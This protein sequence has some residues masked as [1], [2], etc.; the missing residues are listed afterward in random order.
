MGN[1]QKSL[2]GAGLSAALVP[3]VLSISAT[4]TRAQP[5][6]R[7][8]VKEPAATRC[9]EGT[10]VGQGRE[11]RAGLSPEELELLRLRVETERDQLRLAEWRLEQAQSWESRARELVDHGRL[12]IEQFIAAQ[13]NAMVKQSDALAQRAAVQAAEL[14]LAQ[15][16]RG[17]ASDRPVSSPSE[18]RLADLERR[19]A[20]VERAVRSLRQETEH[21]QLDLPIQINSCRR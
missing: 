12:P 7:V 1:W 13:D 6:S 17:T 3:T 8:A 14:R 19:L 10:T 20:A 2:I 18:G 11:P 5:P 21:V 16:Q 4:P 9:A 15:A